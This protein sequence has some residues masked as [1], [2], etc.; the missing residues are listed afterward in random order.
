MHF[1]KFTLCKYSIYQLNPS[2]IILRMPFTYF[3][4]DSYQ[5]KYLILNYHLDM[6]KKKVR[7]FDRV[8][9]SIAESEE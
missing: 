8:I 4:I 7:G 2:L 3:I 1:V 5:N 9:A 6:I